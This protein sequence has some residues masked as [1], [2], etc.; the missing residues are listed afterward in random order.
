MN[1]QAPAP[2]QLA[3]YVYYRVPPLSQ[4]TLAEAVQGLQASLCARHA[5]LQARLMVR[6]DT[7]VPGQGP[8]WMEVYEHPQGVSPACLADLQALVSAWPP[9][10]APARHV[11]MFHPL[12]PGNAGAPDSP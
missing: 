12:V 3:V 9:G 10:M 5:G 4:P 11:E 7:P 1:P 8:T 6:A 2:T